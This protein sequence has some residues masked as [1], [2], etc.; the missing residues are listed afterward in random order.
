MPCLFPMYLKDLNNRG[1]FVRQLGVNF[2]IYAWMMYRTGMC[3]QDPQNDRRPSSGQ[4]F[5]ASRYEDPVGGHY[6][7]LFSFS[8]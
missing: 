5:L 6:C 4:S 2:R 8:A 7:E 1:L 3:L